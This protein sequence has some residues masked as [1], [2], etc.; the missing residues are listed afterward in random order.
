MKNVH[1]IAKIWK[2]RRHLIRDFW[3][4]NVCVAM[5]YAKE[6][7]CSVDCIHSGLISTLINRIE[8][9]R[10]KI[11]YLMCTIFGTKWSTTQMIKMEHWLIQTISLKLS[12]IY[13]YVVFCWK[14]AYFQHLM[15][16]VL[17]DHIISCFHSGT[18]NLAY[19]T[20]VFHCYD[21]STNKLQYLWRNKC[22][23]KMEL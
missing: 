9:A 10:I 4:I 21:K 1:V 11:A 18:F 6:M 14:S 15:C 20:N 3:S 23:C 8:C 5:C 22:Y 7:F 16:Y 17:G 13:I 12:T 2:K 19:S